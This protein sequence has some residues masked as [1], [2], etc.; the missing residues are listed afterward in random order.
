MK[1][2]AP[3]QKCGRRVIM[4]CMKAPGITFLLCNEHGRSPNRNVPSRMRWPRP[5][6]ASANSTAGRSDLS[7]GTLYALYTQ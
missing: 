1:I 5:Q 4:C 2:D 6:H 7:P 3:K